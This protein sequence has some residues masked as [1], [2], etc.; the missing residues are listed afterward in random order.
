MIT[1]LD[2]LNAEAVARVM[3]ATVSFM[4]MCCVQVDKFEKVSTSVGDRRTHEER[5]FDVSVTK[6]S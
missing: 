1:N 6:F 5:R 2:P 4:L 3:A